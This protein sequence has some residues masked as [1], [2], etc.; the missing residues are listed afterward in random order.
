MTIQLDIFRAVRGWL[1][2][3]TLPALTDAQVIP[4][5]DKGPRPALPYLSVK[6]T[7]LHQ[8]LGEDERGVEVLGADTPQEQVRLTVTGARRGVLQL[9]GFGDAPGEWLAAAELALSDPQILMGLSE[10]GVSVRSLGGLIDVSALLDTKIEARWSQDF[11]VTYQLRSSRV[12]IPVA[13]AEAQATL[14]PHAPDD[15][16]ALTLTTTLDLEP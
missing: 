15:P 11:E 8:R 14:Y 4:S 5:D 1:K 16:G 9:R 13:E 10:L 6:L 12:A 7:T 3:A 2:A